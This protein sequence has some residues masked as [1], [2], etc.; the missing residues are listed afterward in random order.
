MLP[1]NEPAYRVPFGVRLAR[2]VLK[3]IFRLLFRILARVRVTGVEHIPRGQAYVVAINHVSLYDPPFAVAFWP[4]MVELIGAVEVWSRPGQ[5]LLAR[6]YGGIPVHRGE[7]DRAM[8]DKV[9][10]VLRSGRPLLMAPEGGRSHETGMRRAR[11]G[12][13]FIVEAADVP[14]VP[15]GIVGTTDDFWQRARRGERPLLEMHIGQPLRLPQLPQ[16]PERRAARQRN[17]DL[18]MQHIAA[19]LPP[20][21]RGVYAEW[22]AA[23]ETGGVL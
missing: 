17:A 4:E 22:H 8:L 10:D 13:A 19:L 15:V 20:E 18:V 6:W 3:G 21:Y 14:V 11:P 12:I 5:N 9:L 1:V 7:V 2:P 16:G 23:G